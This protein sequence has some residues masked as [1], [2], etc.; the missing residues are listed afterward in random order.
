MKSR[1]L[2]GK[3]ALCVFVVFFLFLFAQEKQTAVEGLPKGAEVNGPRPVENIVKH[4]NQLA[5]R[6]N[7]LVKK[8]RKIDPELAG[9][10][11]LIIDVDKNGT[12][13]FVDIGKNT[14]K[15]PEFEDELLHAVSNHKFEKIKKG[16]KKTEVIYPLYFENETG[17]DQ[18]ST[19]ETEESEETNEEGL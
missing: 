2:V 18:E 19:K 6:F 14:I 3:T 13:F 4:M 8:Y 5:P 16:R 10:I 7:F 12:A 1:R 15:N 17:A 11:E 9:M